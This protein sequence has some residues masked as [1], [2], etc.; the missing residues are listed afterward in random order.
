MARRF[1]ATWWGRAWIEALEQRAHLD[2]NRLPR[3]RTYARQDRTSA[4]E[5][6]PGEILAAVQGSRRT[7]YRVR[8][9]VRRF[10]EGEWERF[11]IAV[12]ARA[13]HAAALL[14]GELEPGIVDDARAAGVELLPGPGDL[15][16]HC[17][18]PDWANPCKHAAAVC[19][20]VADELDADP[21]ALLTLRGRRRPEVLE[22]L[23]RIRGASVPQAKSTAPA[24]DGGVRASE[25]W[26][27]DLGD[28]PLP[29]PA[30]PRPGSPAV[31][32]TDPPVSAPFTAD[33]LGLLAVDAARRAWFVHRG[34]GTTGLVDDR[35]TDLT[36]RAADALGTDAWPALTAATGEDPRRLARRA[37][38]WQV[39]GPAGAGAVAQSPWRPDT[40][41]MAAARAALVEAGAPT[42]H[43]R[44]RLNALT[45]GDVQIRLDTDG[46]WWR[47]ER[48]NGAW[49]LAA[50]PASEPDDL[51]M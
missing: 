39:A 42:S 21:F 24:P 33:A 46:Q 18:C 31:W 51:W 20:L 11:L 45:A 5:T 25:A 34:E 12:A 1:G 30:R 23:R 44:V 50:P 41:V 29:P 10:D 35:E 28:L 26:S 13:G 19:Y 9:G 37:V 8:I 7:P 43:L 4:V 2:P 32:P 27:R 36:R 6:R 38:A 47:F 16:P 48:R 49:E 3:G 22:A 17:S 40:R 15:D 14:D